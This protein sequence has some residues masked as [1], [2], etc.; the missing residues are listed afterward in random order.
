MTDLIDKQAFKLAL[1][2][3]DEKER[4]KFPVTIAD[5]IFGIKIYSSQLKLDEFREIF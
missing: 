1:V 3:Y 2:T 5:R 4:E